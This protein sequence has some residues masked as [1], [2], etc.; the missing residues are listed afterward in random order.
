MSEAPDV[1]RRAAPPPPA[2]QR[3]EALALQELAAAAAARDAEAA[4]ADPL[5]ACIGWDLGLCGPAVP[6]AD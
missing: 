2:L 5:A 4:T 1:P 3:L 6:L